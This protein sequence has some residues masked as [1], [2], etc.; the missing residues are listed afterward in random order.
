MLP[1]KPVIIDFLGRMAVPESRPWN[2]PLVPWR[3]WASCCRTL[4][5]RPSNVLGSERLRVD[6]AQ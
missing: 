2:L 4:D 5:Y 1:V 3:A 6:V